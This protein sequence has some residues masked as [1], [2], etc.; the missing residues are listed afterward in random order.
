MP[1]TTSGRWRWPIRPLARRAIQRGLRGDALERYAGEW[2]L[3]IEDISPLV[4]RQREIMRT[5]NLDRL[6]TPRETAYP[7]ADTELAWRLGLDAPAIQG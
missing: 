6:L 3:R 4:A 5:G 2:L 1:V 7:I